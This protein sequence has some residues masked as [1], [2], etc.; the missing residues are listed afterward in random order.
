MVSVG[1]RFVCMQ[2]G[3]AGSVN[4]TPNWHD[5]PTRSAP[6]S[7]LWQPKRAPNMAAFTL[8]AG[9]VA[10]SVAYLSCYGEH[11]RS[12]GNLGL[13]FQTRAAVPNGEHEHAQAVL[14]TPCRNDSP[15]NPLGPFHPMNMQHHQAPGYD[16]DVV[17]RSAW[18]RYRRPYFSEPRP[19]CECPLWQLNSGQSHCPI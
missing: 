2:C 14:G 6:F 7:S 5:M 16:P 9:D 4:I 10:V 11:T 18:Y 3:A 1:W 12:M 19:R 8:D 17:I 13:H 15:G